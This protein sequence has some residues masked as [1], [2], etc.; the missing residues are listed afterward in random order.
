MRILLALTAI[1]LCSAPALADML[2]KHFLPTA[3]RTHKQPTLIVTDV[4]RHGEIDDSISLLMYRELER[5]GCIKVIGIVSIFG[6]G[7]ASTRVVH[8]NLSLRLDELGI[9]GWKQRMLRG[10]DRKSFGTLN[11]EDH[12]RLSEI[13]RVINEHNNVVIAE[14]GP[15][16]ISACLLMNRMVSPDRVKRILGIGGRLKG[17][18]FATGRT[19]VGNLF[20]FRDM[21]IAEDTHAVRWLVEHHPKKLWMI[22]YHAGVGSR[23]IAPEMVADLAPLLTK[24]AHDRA[25][26][27]RKVLGYQGIPS[28]D[29]W[30]TSYFVRGGATRLNCKRMPAAMRYAGSSYRDPMQ[31]YLDVPRA[32]EIIAC[33]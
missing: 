19:L 33:H 5:R 14:L 30:T 15:L 28:W 24:H 4:T 23:T 18:R 12:T 32:P 31:L 1:L 3:C 9:S 16:T 8:E 13:A 21:N 27:L 7:G 6:N 11:A 25:R 22:T 2:T 29:T 17:E 20:A 10:P 26:T